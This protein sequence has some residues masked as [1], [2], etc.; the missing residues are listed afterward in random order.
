[1]A[2]AGSGFYQMLLTMRHHH[3]WRYHHSWWYGPISEAPSGS[4]SPVQ[5]FS[6]FNLLCQLVRRV[7]NVHH[8]LRSNA[9]KIT[10]K[11]P[12]QAGGFP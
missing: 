6:R 11:D 8:R 2:G 3:G 10:R 9:K 12:Q 4:L 7:V 5:G 1:M